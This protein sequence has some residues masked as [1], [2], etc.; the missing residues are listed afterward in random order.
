MPSRKWTLPRST[1]SKFFFRSSFSFCISP[2]ELVATHMSLTC[3]MTIE[4]P[5]F[6]VLTYMQWLVETIS[7]Q[8][9]VMA[10]SRHWFQPH[11]ACIRKYCLIQPAHP[12][13]LPRLLASFRLFHVNLL[14]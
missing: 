6:E 3:I 5:R 1:R 11:A 13:L 14:T 7:Y 12:V 9:L 10:Q 4:V 2:S 8:L